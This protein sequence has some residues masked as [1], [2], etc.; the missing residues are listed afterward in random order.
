MIQ[1]ATFLKF[2]SLIDMLNVLPTDTA[3]REYLE[4]VLWNNTPTCPHCGS[5]HSYTLKTKG[6]AKGMYKC[7]DC[8]QRYTVTV[9]TMFHGS[10]VPLKKWFMA[11]YVFSLHKKGISSYQLA[12]DLELTQKTAWYLLHRI[13]FAFKAE[14]NIDTDSVVEID[15]TFVGGE[16]K[17][18]HEIKKVR[19]ERGGTVSTKVPVLGILER[20]G[21]VKAIAVPDTHKNTLLPEIFATVEDGAVIMTDS[22]PAYKGLDKRYCHL[23]V[24]HS[25]GEYVKGLAHTNNIENF[26]SHMQRGIIGIYHH[27]SPKHLDQYCHEFSYRYN[28]RKQTVSEKFNVSLVNS[29]RLTYSTLIGKVA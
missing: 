21:D 17:N 1:V 12:S 7:I 15:E 13:R 27:V 8:Q 23:S 2:K 28:V 24:N 10:H 11:I 18:K 5:Q 16:S 20:N 4:N 14:L 6:V 29:R 3:C 25:E 26:W 9:G 22:F 19:N